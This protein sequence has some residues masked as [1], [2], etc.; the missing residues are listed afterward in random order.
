[1]PFLVARRCEAVSLFEQEIDVTASDLGQE[2]VRPLPEQ[3]CDLIRSECREFQVD[4]KA[5]ATKAHLCC[6]HCQSP[7]GEIVQ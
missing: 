3:C 1:M 4:A 5:T 6:S 2:P 7:V